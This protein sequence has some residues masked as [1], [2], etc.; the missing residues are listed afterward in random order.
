MA[1][2][3][4]I[5]PRQK[6]INM[7]Y[8]VLTALLAL[9]VSKEILK[10]FHLMEV[11]FNKAQANVDAKNNAVMA[12]F[13]DQ[14]SNNPK[15]KPYYERAKVV[16]K[17]ADDFVKYIEGIKQELITSTDGRKEPEEGEPAD[18]LTELT[19]SDNMEKHANYFV[20]EVYNGKE[21]GR[22]EE[23]QNKIN[24]ALEDMLNAI[25]SDGKDTS[26]TY[27]MDPAAI[28]K[29]RQ[30]SDLKALDGKSEKEKYIAMYFE[31]SPLAAVITMLTKIQN[32]A[33][34]TES[35]IL[36]LLNSSVGANQFKFNKLTAT[37]V[38]PS[39]TV[40]VGEEYSAKVLLVASNTDI[41]PKV[42]LSSG[43]ELPIEDG[44]GVFK[45]R[46]TSQGFFDLK[47]VIKLD[48]DTGVAVFPFET[49]Y[50]AFQ[51]NATISA[52]AMNVLYIGLDNPISVSVP[53]FSPND[54]IVSMS[55]GS[56]ASKGAGKYI[57]K[58]QRGASR[59]A[60]I[61]ASVKMKDGSTRNMG[62]MKYRI[63]QVPKPE[64]KFGTVGSGP[65]SGA[66]L[67]AQNF[68]LAD[69]QGFVFEGVQYRVTKYTFVFVPKRGDAVPM[70][71][72]GPQITGDIKNVLRRAKRGD[73]IIVADVVA[74]GPDGTKNLNPVVIDISN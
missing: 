50:Q 67:Q 24:K 10:S 38:A 52:D 63:M 2:G 13:A 66:S 25:K 60:V 1:G 45:T 74:S 46:P 28:E 73:K 55:G 54:V 20:K 71:V 35:D 16:T 30:S 32:D 15:A 56:L 34:N 62:S 36:N 9:N 14:A 26:G 65:A 40:M 70:T 7:M 43:S 11:S 68:I 48:T 39:S 42:T 57:A 6:M 29:I 69:M 33:K 72:S 27:K 51:G 19:Q 59:E 47:G 61:S 49:Q 23:L 22:G 41:S 58:V 17:I 12:A 3:G 44:M 5:S 21:G 8:L 4:K 37:V 31:H 64:A 18:A 53:G